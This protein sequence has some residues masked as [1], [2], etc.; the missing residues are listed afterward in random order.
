MVH[1]KVF[2]GNRNFHTKSLI[3]GSGM[4]SVL[5]NKGGAGSGSSYS[6][7]ADYE[8]QT[9]RVISGSG[10]DKLSSLMVKPLQGR[11][12]KNIQFSI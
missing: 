1:S 6:S 10:M 7:V 11:K 4:G 9:G 2:L 12:P 8:N 5:L 3:R